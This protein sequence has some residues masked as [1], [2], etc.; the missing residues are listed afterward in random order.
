MKYSNAVLE[1]PSF[2]QEDTGGYECVAENKMGKNIATGRLAFYGTGT[3]GVWLAKT[4]YVPSTCAFV[5]NQTWNWLKRLK[6][7]FVNMITAICRG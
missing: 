1:I 4:N 7:L 2:Q 3:F 5:T 6:L